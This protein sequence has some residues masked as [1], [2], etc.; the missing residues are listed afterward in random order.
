MI[1]ERD[2]KIYFFRLISW[3]VN[4]LVEVCLREKDFVVQSCQENPSTEYISSLLKKGDL[5]SF[6]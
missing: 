6:H 1:K 3:E 4:I 5:F 2:Q